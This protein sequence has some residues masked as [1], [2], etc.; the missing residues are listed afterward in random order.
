MDTIIYYLIDAVTIVLVTTVFEFIKALVSTIQGDTVPKSQGK[1]TLNPAKFFEPIGFM[2]FLFTGFGWANPVETSNRNYK[3][4][5]NGVLLTYGLPIII[6]AVIGA[7]INLALNFLPFL[8]NINYV[9]DGLYLLARNFAAV[10]VFNII[11]VYPMSGSWLLR[12]VLNPNSA[13]KYGQYEKPLQILVVFLLV[14]GWITPFL[15]YI[16]SIII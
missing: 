7:V 4:R 1:L 8:A 11:P 10:A 13:I 15:N 2:L 6:C 3:N 14:L 5:K 12:C 9:S 16:V